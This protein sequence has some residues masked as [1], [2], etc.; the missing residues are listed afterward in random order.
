MDYFKNE[1]I[2]VEYEYIFSSIFT[3]NFFCDYDNLNSPF[4]NVFTQHFQLFYAFQIA[5]QYHVYGS[6][7]HPNI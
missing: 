4:N 2:N 6:K 3:I 5:P 7:P 1:N